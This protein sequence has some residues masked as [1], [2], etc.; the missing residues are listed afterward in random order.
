[1]K[2]CWL[3]PCNK[4]HP[5]CPAYETKPLYIIHCL[6]TLGVIH[7][8]RN[9]EVAESEFSSPEKLILYCVFSLVLINDIT[10]FTKDI[11][12]FTRPVCPL[13]KFGR[14]S[15]CSRR[16]QANDKYIYLYIEVNY[17]AQ[18]KISTIQIS[19]LVTLV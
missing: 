3:R 19:D 16:L 5:L 14:V 1:M 12:S 15:R 11:T 13:K 2:N 17:Y 7:P 18:L 4:S 9:A 6:S 8:K 10:S